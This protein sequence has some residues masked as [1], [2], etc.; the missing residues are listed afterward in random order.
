MDYDVWIRKQHLLG[1]PSARIAKLA[2]EGPLFSP[3]VSA[4]VDRILLQLAIRLRVRVSQFHVVGSARYG[5]SLRDGTTFDARYSDLD[6]A[7]I[8]AALYARCGSPDAQSS[9]E[10]RFPEIDLP[11]RQGEALRRIFDEQSRDALDSFAYVSMAVY[12]DMNSLL[13][14]EGAKI[15]AF[16]GVEKSAIDS[17]PVKPVAGHNWEQLGS[18]VNSGLPKFMG[19]VCETPPSSAS[20]YPMQRADFSSAFGSSPWRRV[21]IAALNE[22]LDD[23]V[24][25]ADVCCCLVGGSFLDLKNAEPADIDV[26]I[27]YAISGQAKFDPG[28]ALQRLRRKFLLRFVDAH[29]VPYDGEP[30]LAIKMASFFT[31]LYGESRGGGEHGRGSVLLIPRPGEN[32]VTADFAS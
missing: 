19:P 11:R 13:T 17:M 6:L 16:L 1:A 20:P 18:V 26:V 27:F 23:L 12:R 10:P 4:V 3:R 24:E 32:A 28:R 25:I 8:D 30:W 9:L 15:D 5:F 7:I 21:L 22:A 29:F 2:L 14:V 31:T